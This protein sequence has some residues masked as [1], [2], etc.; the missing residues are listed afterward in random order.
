[1]SSVDAVQAYENAR[2][3]VNAVVAY[4]TYIIP[5]NVGSPLI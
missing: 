3:E 4:L 2:F 1:M 5:Y